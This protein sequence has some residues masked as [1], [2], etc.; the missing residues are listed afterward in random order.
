MKEN[1]KLLFI[2][3]RSIV[4][5]DSLRYYRRFS[6]IYSRSAKHKHVN[7]VTVLSYQFHHNDFSIFLRNFYQVHIRRPKLFPNKKVNPALISHSIFDNY[8]VLNWTK[9]TKAS[10]GVMFNNKYKWT[11]PS[12]T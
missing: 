5:G 10:H 4:R 2:H 3:Y 6:K 11:V 12:L 8:P 7:R 1:R 9:D